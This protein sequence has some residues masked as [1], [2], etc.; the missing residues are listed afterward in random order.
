MMSPP[1][2]PT[3]DELIARYFAPMAGPDG[4]ALKDDAALFRPRAGHELVM[5]TDA[6]VAGV[7]FFHDDPPAS[8]ARKALGVNMSDLAA[9]GAS[10]SGFLL[11]LALPDD[12]TESWL[13]GF[14]RGLAKAAESFGCPL[15]GGDTV[16]ARGALLIGVTAIGEVPEGRMVPRTTAR[17][18]DRVCV[19][20]TIGDAALGLML[21]QG[22]EVPWATSL[23]P[24]HR[25]ELADRYL[26]PRPRLALA[27]VLRR[28]ATAAMDVSDGFAGDLAKM[29][30]ASG[31]TATIDS[32]L[33][34]LS[35][36]ARQALGVHPKLLDRLLTGGDDYEIL[37][38][39]PDGRLTEFLDVAS[40]AGLPV[41]AVGK[42][43]EGD[44]LPVFR[45]GA[46]EKRYEHGS[47]SH[48]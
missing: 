17:P 4:L 37:C 42:V 39:V 13:E 14:S 6:I 18:G 41:K 24:A 22:Q 28:Y 47:F 43:I 20:G 36:G 32:E 11:T 15:L 8:L 30:R 48:F 1:S 46:V 40:V 9:K 33:V 5:T 21:R 29:M 16:R 2:R 19:S 3:E 45:D 10:P 34:P 35:A 7:H 23:S 12:W 44:G 26:H 25:A 27:A 38:T 31:A